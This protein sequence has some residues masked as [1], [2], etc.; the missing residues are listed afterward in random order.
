MNNLYL[1]IPGSG[2]LEQIRKYLKNPERLSFIE[3][4]E[5]VIEENPELRQS[6]EDFKVE[7]E[8]IQTEMKQI[9]EK[10]K[11][12]EDSISQLPDEERIARWRAMEPLRKRYHELVVL[13]ERPQRL[14]ER[15]IPL[16]IA[17]HKKGYKHN[18]IV[19]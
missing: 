18:Q 14:N 12:E 3:D 9:S 7:D 19:G 16:Y 10:M 6:L 17:L 11:Q 5:Q 2:Y 13:K 1:W 4:V 15:L 8:A